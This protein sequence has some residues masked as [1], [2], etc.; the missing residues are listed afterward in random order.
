MHAIRASARYSGAIHAIAELLQ[1]LRI[2]AM[3]VGG[4]A[5]TSSRSWPRRRRT[6]WR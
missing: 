2:D 4:V 1:K 5:R 6:S 3:F